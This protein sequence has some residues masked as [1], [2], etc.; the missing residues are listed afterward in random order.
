[1]PREIR[2]RIHPELCQACPRCEAASVCKVRA[3]VRMDPEDM[4]FLDVERC[5]DCRLCIEACPF[6]AV[7]LIKIPK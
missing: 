2:I 5:F 3:I 6:G 7:R 1:M 4:P